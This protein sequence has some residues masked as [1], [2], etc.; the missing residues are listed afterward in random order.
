MSN[1]FIQGDWSQM[2][3]WLTAHFS[4]DQVMRGELEHQ[5]TGGPK[6]H[7]L[8]AALLYGDTL[9]VTIDNCRDIKVPLAGMMRPAYDGGKRIGHL[10]NY[11]GEEKMI[12][13]TFWVSM[14]EAHKFCL[15]LRDKYFVT[16]DWRAGLA[17][18]VFGVGIYIC[19]RC[20]YSRTR[21]SGRCPDC[22]TKL[23]INLR[24]REWL[25]KPQKRLATPFGRHRLYEGRR[26][27]GANAVAAQ[28]PQSCGASI[29]YR[30]WD[31][32]RKTAPTPMIIRNTTYDSFLLE[33]ALE[34]ARLATDWLAR[35]MEQPWPQLGGLRLPVELAMG[36]NWN[37]HHEKTNPEGLKEIVYT[38]FKVAA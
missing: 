8:N 27:D 33:V 32:L 14:D 25:V 10:W 7:A 3:T 37:E 1:V 36:N 35:T 11:G 6:I 15:K 26:A 9:G 34:Y 38:P 21:E 12:S 4:G 17:D 19:H 31:R 13:D 30:T 16:A 24:W 20:G 2:E 22:P 23:A 5:L 29:M 18:Q 28:L